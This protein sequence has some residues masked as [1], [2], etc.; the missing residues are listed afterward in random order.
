MTTLQTAAPAPA[1]RRE[2]GSGTRLVPLF[3][4]LLVAMF[5]AALD[6]T[7]FSTALPTIVGDLDGVDQM[8]W[9]TTAYLLA[10]T[11][12]MPIYGKLGDLIGRKPLLLFALSVFVAGSLVGALAGNMSVL[13]IGRAVQGIGGGGLMLLAQAIIADVVP[14]RERG[15]Y[16]GVMG[17][18]FGLS[19]VIGPLLG[20]WF[21]ESLSWRWGFW[22]NV[23]LGILAILAAVFFLKLPKT[24]Q[25][26]RLDVLGIATMA[27]A[28]T[29]LI[30]A[31]SWGGN[32]YEWGSWQIIGLFVAT[33]VFGALF[34]LAER[35][36][37]EPIIPLHLFRKRNFVL[38]TVAA[39]VI[40]IAMFGAIG[41]MPT[42]LQ[43][44]T[45]VSATES[46]LMLLPMVAGLLITSIASGQIVSRTG[47]YKWAPILSMLIA[48]L[49]VFLLST[50]QADTATWVIMAHMFVLGAGLGIGMQNLVL[51]VQNTFPSSEVGT[52]TASNNFFRQIGASL[53]SAVV[54]SVFTSRLTDLLSERMPAQAAAQMGGGGDTNSL[55][56]E[57]VQYLPEKIQDVVVGAYTDALTPVFLWLVPLLGAAFVIVLFIK[58]V[59]LATTV[60]ASGSTDAATA[61]TAAAT[62]TGALAPLPGR[63]EEDLRLG[64]VLSLIVQRARTADSDS[65]L[66]IALARL[67]GD[68]PGSTS[69][70]AEHAVRT[71]ITPAA[72]ALLDGADGDPGTERPGRHRA[73]DAQG[74][75]T[76]S[77]PA[78]MTPQ[79]AAQS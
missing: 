33:A 50:M 69:E 36:A 31:T 15:K 37:A 63:N 14:A 66:T 72:L 18:V 27:I 16:M 32:T 11:I 1:A 57:L 73:Q 59:P 52:A 56:P 75:D 71:L 40:A 61:P 8:L 46:G 13:I 43:M 41:Y 21:T 38:T 53:G 49:G 35:F 29:S 55:T 76:A 62:A 48:A 77:E 45:G 30:L 25:R 3:A 70:R 23:P 42:Y 60:D 10:S 34:V 24:S 6:Q 54:G 67:A 78:L 9:V 44:S 17:A 19:S 7:I 12:M 64:L 4:G 74:T 28:V 68:H 79:L 39:L 47:R 20:G 5:L 65:E 22:L 2:S 58:E 26:A 51:I